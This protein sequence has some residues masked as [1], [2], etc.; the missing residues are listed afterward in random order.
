MIDPLQCDEANLV[1]SR[2]QRILRVVLFLFICQQF[3]CFQFGYPYETMH[4]F[5]TGPMLLQILLFIAVWSIGYFGSRNHNPRLLLAYVV[6]NMIWLCFMIAIL[7]LILFSFVLLIG[8]N[9]MEVNQ[10]Y[11]QPI[12]STYQYAHGTASHLFLRSMSY[13]PHSNP[14]WSSNNNSSSS[15]WNSNSTM[16]NNT[17]PVFDDPD[18]EYVAATYHR[19]YSMYMILFILSGVLHI[20]NLVLWIISIR[21]ARAQRAL[22][23]R[24]TTGLVSIQPFCPSYGPQNPTAYPPTY[25]Q[26]PYPYAQPPCGQTFYP[27]YI[28]QQ[29]YMYPP[30]MPMNGQPPTTTAPTSTPK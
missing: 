10:N 9:N 3:I 15:S 7:L 28:P 30:Q 16:N 5:Q 24:A 19:H 25:P 21:L 1:A 23:L 17:S 6:I 29:M 11:Q 8:L 2:L 12:N 20:L 22:I 4:A 14:D 26:Q 18:E 13:Y 27:P